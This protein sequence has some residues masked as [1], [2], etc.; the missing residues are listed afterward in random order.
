MAGVELIPVV[1]KVVVGKINAI[2]LRIPAFEYNG[3]IGVYACLQGWAPASS[4]SCVFAFSFSR[5][6]ALAAD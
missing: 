6:R 3:E 5:L 4:P 2:H 1:E